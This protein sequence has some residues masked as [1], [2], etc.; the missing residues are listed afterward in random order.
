MAVAC[1]NMIIAG[2]AAGPA[3]PVPGSGAVVWSP[4]LTCCGKQVA[5]AW[6]LI[7][8]SVNDRLTM[9]E[10]ERLDQKFAQDAMPKLGSEALMEKAQDDQRE[11][12]IEMYSA[13]LAVRAKHLDGGVSNGLYA[14]YLVSGRRSESLDTRFEASNLDDLAETQLALQKQYPWLIYPCLCAAFRDTRLSG[15]Q[16]NLFI[17][18][19]QDLKSTYTW[20]P[21]LPEQIQPLDSAIAM[22]IQTAA[23]DQAAM[24][25]NIAAA[26]EP[27]IVRN[28]PREKFCLWYGRVCGAAVRALM[29]LKEWTLQPSVRQLQELEVDVKR[30]AR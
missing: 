3:I 29:A 27:V 26:A 14:R 10:Q 6:N 22:E 15:P 18:H 16:K 11:Q 2:F 25:A 17:Q 7:K 5:Q 9:T 1:Q 20:L 24:E 8:T 30:Q 28:S 13:V 23:N 21:D 4:M 12:T 19:I